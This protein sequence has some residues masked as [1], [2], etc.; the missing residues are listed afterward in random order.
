MKMIFT[1]SRKLN[2]AKSMLVVF[3]TFAT[4][5]TQAQVC[6]NPNT[7]IYGLTSGGIIYPVTVSTANVATA[8]NGSGKGSANQ[9][10]GI[11]YN[12]NT[13]IFYYFNSNPGAGSQQFVAYNPTSNTYT[14][15]ASVGTTNTIHTGCVNFNGT[16]YYCSDISG[17]FYYYSISGNSWTT[18]TSKI[19]DQSGTN[20]STTVINT[21]SSGDMAID[22]Y[23]NLWLITSSASNYG[24]YEIKAPLPT[25]VVASVTATRLI[26]PT[27]TTPNGESFEGIA[28]NALGQLYLSTAD[29]KLYKLTT[30]SSASLTLVGSFN[31]SGVGN[32]L[33]SCS[34][35]YSILPVN[36]VSF[37]AAVNDKT[38]F[39]VWTVSQSIN[40]KGFYVER[41]SDDKT[42]DSLTFINDTAGNYEGESTYSFIDPN[43]APGNN[44][45]RIKQVDFNNTDNYSDTK[46]VTLSSSDKISV[47]PN[48]AKDV[49]YVQ[50]N[51]TNSGSKMEIYDLFGKMIAA[52]TLHAGNN[53][54][55][56][57]NLSVGAY[58]V[59]I[60]K[61]NGEVENQK[62][63][64]Q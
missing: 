52:N 55:N 48:P 37:T 63:I 4:V 11:G 32:D 25:S 26:A 12:S 10:N 62:I 38:V 46:L 17:N 45:Y 40:S 29:D 42:W 2:T 8:V 21:Q 34:Y 5:L 39:L 30:P 41:S 16:G 33:T 1:L 53:S 13:G 58:I 57:S 14:T 51:E 64:K 6:S 61:S 60:S 49:V 7:T 35:P 22:G 20:V 23:G 28:F 59:H 56:V 47:W 31:T 27:T 9:A 50:N 3:I 44:Y 24:L 19:V 36:W 18:L 54:I 43:P 15:L